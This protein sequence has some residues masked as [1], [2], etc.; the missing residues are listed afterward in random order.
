M[1][2]MAEN[3]KE[4]ILKF[5]DNFYWG[6]A[7]SSHQVE[8]ENHND[9][10][11][12]E[13]KNAE[14]FAKEAKN[15]WQD[16]QKEKFP[17]MFNRENYI[18]GIACDHY[19]RFKEDFN[20]AKSLNQNAHRFSIEWSRIEPEEGKFNKKEI[21]HYREVIM[22]LRERGIEPFITLWH[23]TNPV[24]ISDIGGWENKKTI[25]YFLRYAEYLFN[26]YRGLV[27][28]YVPLNEPGTQMSF[29]YIFGSQPPGVKSLSRANKVFKN[30]MNAHKKVYLL[31][32][33]KKYGLQIGCSH[34][35]FFNKP[36]K[37]LPWNFLAAKIFDYV[38]DFRFLK[39]YKKY[40][41]FFGLQYYQTN[42]VNLKIGGKILGLM[43]NKEP[44]KWMN[45]LGWEIFPEGIY[46]VVKAVGKYGKPIF[47][48]ENGLP[49]ATDENRIKFITEHLKWLGKAIAE[50]ADV[51][52]YFYWSLLDNF[53]FVDHRGFWPRFG[54]VEI[55]Y[56]TLERKIRPSAKVY[57]EICRNG[58]LRI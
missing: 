22:A 53:E 6:A 15:K 39:V 25:D 18:S 51:R 55:N 35:I 48:T 17:E 38:A 42:Y 49:D 1:W 23:W 19:H 4:K 13:K 32:N 26:E 43:E 52:G 33:A 8:G 56:E 46:H 27:K 34:F 31:N 57:A 7:T 14:Q 21:E 47:I 29:G 37:N 45:D 54:L 20:I 5:P 12:W 36:Y 10:T 2:H 41:D 28:F 40:S 11:E 58:E 50:G 24:W 16:W 9:W 30:L 44:R 3:N